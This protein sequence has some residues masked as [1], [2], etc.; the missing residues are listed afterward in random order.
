MTYKRLNDT[1]ALAKRQVD[2][3]HDV[4]RDPTRCSTWQQ[5]RC[6]DGAAAQTTKSPDVGDGGLATAVKHID[7]KC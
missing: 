7:G 1:E 4:S 5:P 2:F 3:V 6:V